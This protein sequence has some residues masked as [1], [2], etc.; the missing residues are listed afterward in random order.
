[1]ETMQE[2]LLFISVRSQ[3]LRKNISDSVFCGQLVVLIV[4]LSYCHNYQE[5]CGL[6]QEDFQ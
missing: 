1:M 2:T 6:K 4:L 5:M 3:P